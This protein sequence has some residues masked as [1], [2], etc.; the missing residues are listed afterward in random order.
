MVFKKRL[1]LYIEKTRPLIEYYKKKELLKTFISD[2]AE[3][4]IDE[5]VEKVLKILRS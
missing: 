2:K 4:P 5:N 1:E 3:T